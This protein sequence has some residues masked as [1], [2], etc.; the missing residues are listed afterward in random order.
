M[1]IGLSN[2][3][4]KSSLDFLFSDL[5]MQRSNRYYIDENYEAVV[6]EL[7]QLDVNCLD[8]KQISFLKFFFYFL[9]S[10][11]DRYH[12]QVNLVNI[13]RD[14]KVS[15]LPPFIIPRA[16]I[17]GNYLDE[18]VPHSDFNAYEGYWRGNPR[19]LDKPYPQMLFRWIVFFRR[20]I[21]LDV[22]RI[23]E[24]IITYTDCFFSSDDLKHAIALS[25][26]VFDYYKHK[27][28]SH[29][30]PYNISNRKKY[31]NTNTVLFKL[32]P[33]NISSVLLII[34]EEPN[35]CSI[36]DDLTYRHF[37]IIPRELIISAFNKCSLIESSK[38]WVIFSSGTIFDATILPTCFFI[39]KFQNQY[40]IPDDFLYFIDNKI[41]E[42]FFSTVLLH[43]K[44]LE[45]EIP[46]L[47]S[48]VLNQNFDAFQR[49]RELLAQ[50]SPFL[51]DYLYN[52]FSNYAPPDSMSFPNSKT[53]QIGG[54]LEKAIKILKKSP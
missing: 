26:S 32:K 24:L 13:Q 1:S 15:E 33:E 39:I 7:I 49:K 48:I 43:H 5:L 6:S 53:S 47:I 4:I 22:I 12:T 10:H 28:T 23:I 45:N 35:G 46:E 54:F 52:S 18:L 9:R 3:I 40:T 37:D 14:R 42:L 17:L 51:R 50:Y 21:E 11:Y 34:N 41:P 31:Q 44:T 25:K 36:S 29:P 8:M 30:T 2:N 19:F 16:N 38:Q 27:D 20:Y